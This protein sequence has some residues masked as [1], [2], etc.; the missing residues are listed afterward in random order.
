MNITPSAM[1]LLTITYVNSGYII[2][3]QLLHVDEQRLPAARGRE[4]ILIDMKVTDI[5][6]YLQS[7]PDPIYEVFE[8]TQRASELT[9]TSMGLVWYQARYT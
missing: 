1:Y 5:E 3:S 4:V 6:A 8:I 9:P 7:G 2:P